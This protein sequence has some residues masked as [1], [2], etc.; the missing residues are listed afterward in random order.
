MT[1][2]L[3]AGIKY[4]IAEAPSIVT[5]TIYSEQWYTMWVVNGRGDVYPIKARCLHWIDKAGNDVFR[6]HAG[7][8]KPNPFPT[9]AK[10]RMMGEY[11]PMA[12]G[13]I[14][15]VVKDIARATGSVSGGTSYSGATGAVKGASNFGDAFSRMTQRLAGETATFFQRT[16]K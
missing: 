8:S 12:L 4:R 16:Y 6:M 2:K 13:L 7:P 3:R 1:G 15:G 11:Y 5:A 10:N 9:R 14:D